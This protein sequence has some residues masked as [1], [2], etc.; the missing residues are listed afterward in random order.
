MHVGQVA[1]QWLA[2]THSLCMGSES[3]S[4]FLQGDPKD[5]PQVSNPSAVGRCPRHTLKVRVQSVCPHGGQKLARP[6]SGLRGCTRSC[7]CGKAREPEAPPPAPSP[8]P[9]APAPA[10]PTAVTSP[11]PQTL[12]QQ[13]RQTDTRSGSARPL[14]G[15]CPQEL[16]E[17]MREG[18]LARWVLCGGRSP[19]P[20]GWGTCCPLLPWTPSPPGLRLTPGDLSTL[21]S[22]HFQ[23][24]SRNITLQLFPV[25]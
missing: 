5:H 2:S 13:Q 24:T 14:G 6:C 17:K 18:G 21:T 7:R 22:V 15:L 9:V 16:A 19:E 20:G 8:E 1:A 11:C 23:V 25:T 3:P 12:H 4:E 10:L